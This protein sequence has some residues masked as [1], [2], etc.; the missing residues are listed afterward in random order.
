MLSVKVRGTLWSKEDL[1]RQI[2]RS[3]QPGRPSGTSYEGVTVAVADPYSQQHAGPYSRQELAALWVRAY[4][5]AYKVL[6]CREDAEDIAVETLAR[7]CANRGGRPAQE[8]GRVTKVAA[9]LAIDTWRKQRRHDRSG[10]ADTA[11]PPD[12]PNV[13]LDMLRGL[14]ALAPRQR[15]AL[16]LRYFMDLSEA[17]T[18]SMLGVSAGAVKRHTNRGLSALR[19]KRSRKEG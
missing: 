14:A 10:V 5:S 4:Q 15:D 8:L 12:D 13:R 2:W 6:S 11:V 9:N 19:A 7:L 3:C 1:G 18:A 16:I 17:D